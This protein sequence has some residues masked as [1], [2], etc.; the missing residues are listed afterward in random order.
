MDLRITQGLDIP[1]K[2]APTGIP[3]PLHPETVALDLS[4][5]DQH[6]FRLLAKPGDRI[7]QGQPLVQDKQYEKR[8][9]VSPGTGTVQEFKRGLKRRLLSIPIALEGEGVHPF[10]PLHTA[11]RGEVL[12]RLL[13][14]GVFPHLRQRP[15][16]RLA[17]PTQE[18]RSIF[19]KALE[20]AP[21]AVPPE[22]Q[23]EGYEEDFTLGLKILSLLT[24]G[25]VHL[26]YR[27]GSTFK[28]FTESQHVERHTMRGPHPAANLSIPIHRIDPIRHYNAVVWTTDVIGV[29]AI[30]HLF[31]R[32]LYFTPRILSLAGTGIEE[33]KR[34]YVKGR[35]GFPVHSLIEGRSIQQ[36]VRWISGDP[37]TGTQVAPDDHLGFYD[38][39]LSAIPENLEKQEFLH[40][41]RLGLHKYTASRTYFSRLKK[42]LYDFTTNQHGEE[43]PF[44][45]GSPYDKVMPLP[46]NTMMLV[47]AVMAE[48]F[49][50]A[51]T[52]GL[53]EVAPEDFA[54]PT[55]VDPSKIEMVEVIRNG[56][57]QYSKEV[58]S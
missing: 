38:T 28:P 21:F 12:A 55:F 34:T 23:V 11:D 41:F 47:K 32:G 15:F 25:K 6:R 37:L 40:F 29:L 20:T 19:V 22:Y 36:P 3:E 52:L 53:L 48:D 54:L 24:Q 13:E 10:K 49:E 44:I 9:F 7:L 46:V 4:P 17:D 30:G 31:N 1:I 43:R 50:L 14:A 2:G 35:A 27:H 56:L 33:G 16:D 5:F 45:T 18:P 8:L 51:E 57:N 26:V 39:I 42:K 58:L